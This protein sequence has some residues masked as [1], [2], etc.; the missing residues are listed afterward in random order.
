MSQ[1]TNELQRIKGIGTVFAK[2]FLEAGYD[3]FAKIAA[4]GEEG[5][6]TIQGMN[7]QMAR[8]ILSQ[9]RELAGEVDK[10]RTAKMGE[11]TQKAASMAKQV[12]DI[13]LDVQKRFQKEAAGKRGRKVK[14][15]IAKI[16]IF[17]EK[18]KGNLQT[19]VKRNSKV[20]DK[21]EKKLVGLTDTGLKGLEKG[22]RKAR[23][24]LKKN[25]PK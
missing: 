1:T 2:R 10:T 11:L 12:Q 6:R 20:L 19:K 14:K 21:A 18:A 15:E 8:S 7:A 24:S 5:L 3:T 17:L 25:F 13:A 4:A 16:L 22:L 9:A 23:K